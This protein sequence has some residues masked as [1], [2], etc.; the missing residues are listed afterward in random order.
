MRDKALANSEIISTLAHFRM[1]LGRAWLLREPVVV[2]V[3]GVR[4][5]Q[6]PAVGVHALVPDG[7]HPQEGRGGE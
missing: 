5:G 7:R 2:P 3:H 1:G 4:R 6:P